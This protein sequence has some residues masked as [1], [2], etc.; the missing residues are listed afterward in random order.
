MPT[1]RVVVC[2]AGGFIGAHLAERLKAEGAWVRGVDLRR[3]PY[4]EPA[5]TR[6]FDDWIDGDLRSPEVATRALESVTHVYQLAADMGGAGYLF[7]GENDAAVMHNSALVNLNVAH[8]AAA[9]PE[10]PR[11]LFTSSACVYPQANQADPQNPQCHEDSAYPA[12]PDSEYG[13]EKLFSERLFMAFA[14][15][16]GLRVRV[17]RLHNVFGPQGAWDNGREKAP[18][19][20][21]RKV[22]DAEEGGIVEIWGDG[23]QTRSFL[24]VDECVEGLLRIMASGAERPVNLGSEELISIND[25]ARMV[26]EILGKLIRLKHVSGPQG[27]RGRTSDNTRL[28]ATTGW[29]PTRSLREGLERT[30]AWI[31][32]ERAAGRTDLH[33]HLD[34]E[35]AATV[36]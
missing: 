2:G 25:L 22:I 7:G 4:R 10:S 13:W 16:A 12:D 15:N 32:A 31:A 8:A 14:R 18:A 1:Q 28:R 29:E 3:S 24:Y 6:A 19:A 34:R 17:V 5:W 9:Q 26:A 11:V 21:C 27:V 30:L 36:V 20:I 33:H 35:A 23:E